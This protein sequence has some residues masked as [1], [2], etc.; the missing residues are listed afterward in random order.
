MT[1]EKC[2][3][4]ACNCQPDNNDKYCSPYCH[5]A[6]DLIEIACDC[7][8]PDCNRESVRVPLGSGE[9]AMT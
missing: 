1:S 5:D 4:P 6:G 2:A 7:G 3:H 8:H 9:P